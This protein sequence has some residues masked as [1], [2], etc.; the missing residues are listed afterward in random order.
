MNDGNRDGKYANFTQL[1]M[2]CNEVDDIFECFIS[3]GH[4]DYGGANFFA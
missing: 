2:S 1:A 3:C 4:A